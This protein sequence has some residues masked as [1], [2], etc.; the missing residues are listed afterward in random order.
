[1]REV[2]MYLAS[3]LQLAVEHGH[4]LG[5]PARGLR[6][7]RKHVRAE[8][9]ALTP[10]ELEVVLD[11]MTGR[12]RAITTLGGRLGLR[13]A[14]IVL[15]RWNMLVDGELHI[16]A[17]DTKRSAA[18][19]RAIKLDRF[20]LQEL[21]V[22]QVESGGRGRDPIVGP[23]TANALKLWG[24]KRLRPRVL[25]VTEG[26]IPKASTNMLRHSHASAL[27]YAGFTVPE[28]AGRMGHTQ[29]THI[30]HYA[31][32]L[33]MGRSERYEGLDDLYAAARQS[34]HSQQLVRLGAQ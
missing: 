31:H 23:M 15:A 16:G 20:T 32:I 14:E 10:R 7:T 22:W 26:R 34:T 13:P 29:Q 8:K 2:F 19:F 9:Q 33:A 11:G 25:A 6:K 4:L 27:H 24:T 17:R 28:A 5:N 1:V 21:R 18:K 12:D 30:L 3:V